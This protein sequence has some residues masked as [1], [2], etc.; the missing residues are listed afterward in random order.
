MRN[1]VPRT[2][3]GLI[4]IAAALYVTWD[5]GLKPTAALA[6]SPIGDTPLAGADAKLK[7]FSGGYPTVGFVDAAGKAHHLSEFKGKVVVMNLWA[8]WCAPCQKEM[9]TLAALQKSFGTAPILIAPVSI[10]SKAAVDKAKAFMA[11]NKPL[12]F[13]HDDDGALS[14]VLK[15]SVEGYPTTFIYDRQGHLYGVV[16]GEADWSSPRTRA[17]LEKLALEKPAKA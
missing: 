3:V 12:P 16:Q 15:P 8:T 7:R 5:A 6:T 17:L 13:F 4:A 10:D 14:P 11:G 9:P 1:W 2:V